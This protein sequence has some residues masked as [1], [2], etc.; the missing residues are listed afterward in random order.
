MEKLNL[1]IIAKELEVAIDSLEQAQRI[2]IA[3]EDDTVTDE[4]RDRIRELSKTCL[5]LK[6]IR[7][8]TGIMV[9]ERVM[10]LCNVQQ[11]ITEITNVLEDFKDARS[12]INI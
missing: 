7:E 9:L 3:L 5:E 10:H 11:A 12:L 6:Y 1:R 2:L 4:H 8:E